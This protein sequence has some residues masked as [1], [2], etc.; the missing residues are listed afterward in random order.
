ML[1]GGRAA[2]TL[3]SHRGW[4]WGLAQA[5]DGR[6]WSASFDGTVSVWQ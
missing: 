3:S 4:V 6:I 5:T 2:L 1:S